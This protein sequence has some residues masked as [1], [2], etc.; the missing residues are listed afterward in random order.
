M[1]RFIYFCVLSIIVSF[2]LPYELQAQNR[3][4]DST[5][6]PP[7]HTTKVKPKKIKKRRTIY[8][9]QS[10]SVAEEL[11]LSADQTA[12]LE[13]LYREM[14]KSHKLALT[15]IPKEGDKDESASS[16]QELRERDQEKLAEGLKG[17]MTD[18]Q[19]ASGLPL[20]CCF[21][22]QWDSFTNVLFSLNLEREKLKAAMVLVNTYIVSLR[23]SKEKSVS[24]DV[25]GTGKLGSKSGGKSRNRSSGRDSELSRTKS[26]K[27]TGVHSR[28]STRESPQSLKQRLDMSLGQLLT[29]EQ[30][31]VWAESSKKGKQ[32]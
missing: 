3:S 7:S 19:I 29:R 10:R 16:V 25:K 18:E 27:S 5:I 28:R 8:K 21:N 11:G 26:E 17:I 12:K 23:E 2:L 20:L 32:K 22:P 6:V 4:T 14:R 31:A 9:I 15:K 30:Y 1:K 13:V 24:T